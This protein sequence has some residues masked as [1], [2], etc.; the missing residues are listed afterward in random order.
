MKFPKTSM[1]VL[2]VAVVGLAAVGYFSLWG[3]PGQMNG[4]VKPTADK[5]VL[6]GMS[7]GMV[8]EDRWKTDMDL[9]TSRV[10]ELGGNVLIEYVNTNADEQ[11]RQAEKLINSGVQVL[12]VLPD[13][14]AKAAAIVDRAHKAGVK[15]IAYDRLIRDSDVDFYVSFDNVKVGRMEAEGITNLIKEGTFAYVGGA[16]TDNNASLLKEGSMAV[17]KPLVDSGAVKLAVDTFTPNW[18]PDLAYKTIKDYL[19][20][21]GK[22]DA[23]VAGNDG[24]AFGV[25]QALEEKGLAGKVPVSGQ[26]AELAACRRVV[27]GTQAVT[28]YKP[29]HQIASKAAE[30]AFSMAKGE[31]PESNGAV[32][33]GRIQVPSYL[34]EPI[35]VTAANM[36]D[37]VI[38]DGFHTAEEIYA[39]Q[40]GR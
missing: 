9:F 27:A 7:M 25:I 17:L 20:T 15:V 24:T 29:I 38:K 16:P 23:V 3:Q 28:V 10:E 30:L 40:A 32:D 22:L 8:K 35:A 31:K 14:A 26:D 33:N 2:A 19:A 1:L 37:T 6:I 39:N 18:Q 11:L 12:V 4:T 5:P 34:L 21:G 13:N 36:A